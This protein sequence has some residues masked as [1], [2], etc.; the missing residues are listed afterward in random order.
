MVID[1]K[2]LMK[3][4]TGHSCGIDVEVLLIG[5]DGYLFYITLAL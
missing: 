2:V 3:S 4:A 5:I 1:D